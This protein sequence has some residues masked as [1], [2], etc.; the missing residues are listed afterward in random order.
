MAPFS[1]MVNRFNPT[2]YPSLSSYNY[3]SDNTI[4]L[5]P[6]EFAHDNIHLFVSNIVPLVTITTEPAFILAGEAIGSFSTNFQINGQAFI[7]IETL[8]TVNGV[9][10]SMDPSQFLSLVTSPTASLNLDCNEMVTFVGDVVVDKRPVS[11]STPTSEPV[12]NPI[13]TINVPGHEFPQPFELFLEGNEEV[14]SSNTVQF[15]QTSTFLMVGPIPVTFCKLINLALF[16]VTLISLQILIN[17]AC[18]SCVSAFSST[19]QYH[20]NV[21]L[22]AN[23]LS[24]KT[25]ASITPHVTARMQGSVRVGGATYARVTVQGN[26]VESTLPLTMVQDFGNWPM[27]A[28]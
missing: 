1:G 2:E 12:G 28:R 7:H 15:F 3:S 21:S 20:N 27:V 14:M 18:F 9:S 19:G 11:M 26:L 23:L 4:V 6:T 25:E 8:K 24:K 17:D 16:H 13:V 22:R 10:Y 5:R